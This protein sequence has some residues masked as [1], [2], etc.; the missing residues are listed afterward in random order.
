MKKKTHR[1]KLGFKTTNQLSKR[2]FEMIEDR[3]EIIRETGK[4]IELRII[5]GLFV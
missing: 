1:T 2:A 5:E 4:I 3:F